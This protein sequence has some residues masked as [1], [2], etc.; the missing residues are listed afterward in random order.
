MASLLLGVSRT[1]TVSAA[2]SSNP[3]PPTIDFCTLKMLAGATDACAA[4]LQNCTLKMDPLGLASKHLAL[5]GFTYT[6]S[7]LDCLALK[8]CVFLV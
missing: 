1:M 3:G 6:Q 8:G 2:L 5:V 7:L 4:S